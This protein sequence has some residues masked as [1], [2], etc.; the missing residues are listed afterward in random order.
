MPLKMGE[1]EAEIEE[2]LTRIESLDGPIGA[3]AYI[4]SAG[5]FAQAREL[6]NAPVKGVLHGMPIGV[7][8][9]IDVAGMP[10]RCGTPI[11]ATQMA[12]IDAH[13]V[14]LAKAAGAIV[15][16]KTVTT[17][18]ATFNPSRTRNPANLDHTPGGSSAGSA[19]AVAAGMVPLAFGTQTAGSVIRPAAYCGVFGYKPSFR[20]VSRAGVKLQSE[21][22]DTVGVLAATIDDAM[23]WYAA[24]SGSQTTNTAATSRAS[25]RALRIAIITNLMD[26]AD[27]EMNVAIASAAA[28]LNAA[29][30]Q[31]REIRLPERFDQ[32]Q[33]DQRIIQLTEN[34]RH[35]AVEHRQFREQLSPP[36]AAML[37]EGAAISEAQ[38]QAALARTNATREQTDA[39][40]N[41][42]D[43][44]L[45]P[46]A[47]GAAPKGLESTGD[48]VFN[49]LITAMHLP[50]INIPVYR[51][52]ARMPLGLQ[53]IG[54]R[55]QDEKLFATAM[56][57][58]E[59]LRSAY[60]D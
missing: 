3:W 43:A 32:A 13:C 27:A 45:M 2:C 44:W 40:F 17:E 30:L 56:Q 19:A 12:T 57:V 9:I 4:D 18:L 38:Y 1:C 47:Q 51:S 6:D 5:A 20:I 58:N 29:G 26:H 31:A 48:P 34:A 21:T 15:I 59:I 54:A 41:D 60:R 35:Y 14:A 36:L 42:V 33:I 22:L 37:D 52:H 10:T 55:Q 11:Y 28:T 46:S 39:T 50:A 53:L 25:P 24:M 49:R 8:D 7:K 23:K 16:G